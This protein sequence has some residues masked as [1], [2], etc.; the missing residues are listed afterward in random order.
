MKKHTLTIPGVLII[1]IGLGM[2][3]FGVSM[4]AYQGPPPSTF[5]SKA[6]EYSFFYWLP[7]IAIGVVFLIIP[8]NHETETPPKV[9]KK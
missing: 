2:F 4:F 1:L 8:K 5:V 6:G 3:C 7:T 9:R